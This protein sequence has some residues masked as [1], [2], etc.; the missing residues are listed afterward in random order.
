MKKI[1]K[2]NSNHIL[3]FIKCTA[4]L[5]LVTSASFGQKNRSDNDDEQIEKNKSWSF[6]INTGM[7]FA[8][9]YHA[10]FYN[11]ADGNQ[12]ELSFILDNYYHR[13]EIKRTL[14]DS[15]ALV[16]MPTDMKYNPAFC[17][18]FSIVKKFNKH[19]GVFAQF[20]F[21]RLKAVDYFT[22]KIGA[23]P[24]GQAFPNLKNYPIWGKEDRVNIDVGVRGEIGFANRIS[25]FLE[26]GLNI[27]NTRVKQNSI[28]IENLEFSLINIYGNQAYIPN[29][30]L[31]EYNIK[32]GGLG[33]GAFISPGIEF[34]FDENAAIDLLGSI[35][36]TKINLMHYSTFK[37]HYNILLRFVFNTSVEFEK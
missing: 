14:N 37:L 19:F 31:Q 5:L 20:N 3:L 22:L 11:G 26:G 23:T 35:Y 30:Q 4:V 10:N 21:S 24:T 2:N 29:T 33:I 32:Q 6:S 13:Q 27:N 15:F 9:K 8:N 12:N 34:R 28:A 1:Q 17:V 18:G 16:G 25:G 7:A 36:W